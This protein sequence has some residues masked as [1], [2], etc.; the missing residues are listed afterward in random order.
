M[1]SSCIAVIVFYCLQHY[2]ITVCI[3]FSRIFCKI[4]VEAMYLNAGGYA[5]LSA[6]SDILSVSD[7]LFWE[8]IVFKEG[9]NHDN[10]R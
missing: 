7:H 1:A 4:R 3:D 6:L 2:S 9:E 5:G 10:C 8:I